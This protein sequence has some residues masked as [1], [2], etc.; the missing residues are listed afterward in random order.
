MLQL[1]RDRSQGLVVGVIVFFICLTFALFGVQQ[2]LD[3][4]SVVAVAEVNGQEVTLTDYQRAFQQ[5]RQR[6]QAMFGD[7][8]DP[9]LWGGETAKLNALDF[10]VN[11]RVVIQVVEKSN[12][13]ASDLQVAN[14]IRT[15]PQ[16]ERD[17]VFSPELYKALI[18]NIGFSE[19]GFEQQVRKDIVV[20]QLRAGIAATA[21]ATA[22]ELQQLAQYSQ[23]ARD[24]GFGL[25]GIEQFREGIDPSRAELETFY[26]ERLET[27]R[28][29]EKLALDYLDLSIETLM[30]EIPSGEEQL[31]AYYETNAGL[32]T[33]QEQRNANHILIQVPRDGSDEEQA[34]AL[35]K[36]Q[37]L[38]EKA[39]AGGD[40]EALATESSDDVGSRTDGGETGFF[41]RD[42]MAP[43]FEEAVFAMSEGDISEPI[44]TDFGFHIIRLKAVQPGG[45]KPYD[46][47]HDDIAASYQR[48][49]AEKLFFEQAQALSDIAY[50][51]PDA[52]EPAADALGLSIEQTDPISRAEIASRFAPKVAEAA[53][54][55][56]VL[57][58]GLNSEALDISNGRVIA[59]R[60]REHI[61]SRVPE[62]DEVE[63]RVKE[64]FINAR[65]REGIIVAGDALVEKLNAGAD[66]Q[67]VMAEE[68]ITWEDVP[69]AN[70]DSAK[71]N[72]AVARAAFKTDPPADGST[73]YKG[74]AVGTGDY[75][76]Y[77]VSNVSVPEIEQLSISEIAN[78]RRELTNERTGTTWRDFVD[79]LKADAKIATF[80]DRL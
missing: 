57:V 56:E 17:G 73:T 42:V 38:R 14:Y 28:I 72:R 15:S 68:S 78:L 49:E 65:A 9:G 67:S 31:R 66:V 29:D 43:E 41:G 6:A 16:F 54:D 24:V 46:E 80:P 36:A 4:K 44:R 19:L 62:L 45:L 39:L 2:Y 47:V 26:N 30:S 23:Q 12:I 3:A 58:E 69:A 74:V 76:I 35:E 21:F 64:D 37:M 51:Q 27:Y 63:A 53:F 71:L 77:S 8:F 20:N 5:L 50:E 75:A 70:R 34:N 1:I 61:A 22:E 52:L 55:P 59:V 11:E 10:L 18:R 32:F 33:A 13:Q 48:D 25:L 40:F 7:A 79:L 60:V